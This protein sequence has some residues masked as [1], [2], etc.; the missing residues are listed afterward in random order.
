MRHPVSLS[1]AGW[2]WFGVIAFLSVLCTFMA[3]TSAIAVSQTPARAI[4]TP[5]APPCADED[6]P[7]YQPGT[8][9]LT[10]QDENGH[11]LIVETDDLCVAQ[12]EMDLGF[13]P[14]P[15]DYADEL[16]GK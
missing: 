2:Y 12:S 16:R 14:I 7:A 1:R 6:W 4:P 8:I 15:K 5:T 3:V 13:Y 9:Y 11:N 10:K